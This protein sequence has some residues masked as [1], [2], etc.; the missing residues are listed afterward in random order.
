MRELILSNIENYVRNNNNIYDFNGHSYLVNLYFNE[1]C[2]MLNF[3]NK[4]NLLQKISLNIIP[5]D[6]LLE[7]Y[8][9][10]VINNFKENMIKNEETFI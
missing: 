7:I 8:D 1:A 10:I 9:F 4:K 2:L 3:L 5:N 6:I